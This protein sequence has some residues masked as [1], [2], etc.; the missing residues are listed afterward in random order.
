MRTSVRLRGRARAYVVSR[1]DERLKGTDLSLVD[2]FRNIT[3]ADRPQTPGVVKPEAGGRVEMAEHVAREQ[4]R[5]DDLVRSERFRLRRYVGAQSITLCCN[6]L[7][8]TFSC[9]ERT[10]SAYQRGFCGPACC[11]IPAVPV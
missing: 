2:G 10:Q 11:G 8:T 9:C 7:S 3:C 5:F 4:R 6:A 1:F